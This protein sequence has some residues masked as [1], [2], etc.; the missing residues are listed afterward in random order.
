MDYYN[1]LAEGYDELHEAEQLAKLKILL[2]YV[3]LKGKI[4]DVGAGTCIVARH[5]GKKASVVS[6]DPSKRMLVR[7]VGKRHVAKAEQ[8]PFPDHTFDIV[9]S[10]TALH[11][12]DLEKAL[13]EMKRVVK[14]DGIV[15]IS[16]LKKSHTLTPF[17]GLL[18]R[19]FGAFEKIDGYQD[20]LYLI[21]H[22]K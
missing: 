18:Q 3:Q 15:A 13:V 20:Y 4:L 21:K 14:K 8:L 16:F 11:H 12:C 10:L 9:V 5:L 7:G 1:T 19:H 2:K 6:V 17:E 22:T